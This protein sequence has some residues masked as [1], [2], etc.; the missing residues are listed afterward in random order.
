MLIGGIP[1]GSKVVP[2]GEQRLQRGREEESLEPAKSALNY[3]FFGT[4]VSKVSDLTIMGHINMRIF[5]HIGG[6]HGDNL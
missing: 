4:W 1:C 6:R 2:P 3:F 5:L